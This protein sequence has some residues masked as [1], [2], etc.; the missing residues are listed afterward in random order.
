MSLLLLLQ[1]NLRARF[2]AQAARLNQSESFSSLLSHLLAHPVIHSNQYAY[3]VYN[4][5]VEITDNLHS[6]LLSL[7]AHP[8][9]SSEHL[10]PRAKE[11]PQRLRVKKHLNTLEKKQGTFNGKECTTQQHFQLGLSLTTAVLSTPLPARF[12]RPKP[13]QNQVL[14]KPKPRN[15]NATVNTF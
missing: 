8:P 14:Y 11:E 15:S 7:R 3:E 1:P 12:M 5:Q 4:S 2:E 13:E 6:K 10:A 9:C